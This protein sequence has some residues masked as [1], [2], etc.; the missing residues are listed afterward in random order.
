[1]AAVSGRRRYLRAMIEG[2]PEGT[3]RGAVMD[4]LYEAGWD[5]RY[6]TVPAEP[7]SGHVVLPESRFPEEWGWEGR[8]EEWTWE[9]LIAP[10]ARRIAL[11]V[12]AALHSRLT[13]QAASEGLPLNRWI[14]NTLTLAL[15]ATPSGR[16]E[17]R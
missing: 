14:I 4:A 5:H 10:H 15:A 1:V 17:R 6:S 13:L 12:S 2:V 16:R 8:P 7:F 11:D 9:G 3:K